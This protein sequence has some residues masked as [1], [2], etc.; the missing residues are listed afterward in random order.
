[1][2]FEAGKILSDQITMG[3][4]NKRRRLAQIEPKE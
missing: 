3:L 4:N 2:L 1:M